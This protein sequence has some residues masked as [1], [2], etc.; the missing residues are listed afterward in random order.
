MKKI[1]EF[2][3]ELSYNDENQ[4][5]IISYISWGF[6]DIIR[7][8]D[9]QEKIEIT[10]IHAII[11][12]YSVDNDLYIKNDNISD[13]IGNIINLKSIVDFF[14]NLNFDFTINKLEFM[15]DEIEV[16]YDDDSQLVI[17][18]PFKDIE[19]TDELLRKIVLIQQNNRM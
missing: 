7:L 16:S 5:Y 8:F 19:K 13:I 10:N 17:V 18:I 1:E 3:F 12:D 14:T 15:I 6:I 4:L 11:F 2:S 9:E